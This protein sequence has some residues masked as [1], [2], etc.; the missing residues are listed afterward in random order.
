MPL[1]ANYLTLICDELFRLR[2]TIQAVEKNTGGGTD[3]YRKTGSVTN[4]VK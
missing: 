2:V 4:A 1:L 3:D